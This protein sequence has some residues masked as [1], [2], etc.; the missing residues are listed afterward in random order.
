MLHIKPV[1][2]FLCGIAS[3]ELVA[4]VTIPNPYSGSAP[5]NYV[6]S[7]EAVK[8]VTN[9]NDLTAVVPV[10]TAKMTTQYYDGLGRLIQT[11]NKQGSMETGAAAKDLVS[12]VIYDEFG[13]E[14]YQYL[15]FA[16]NNTG[17]NTSVSDG[18]FKLNPFQQ[19]AVF[20]AAQFPGETF[21]YGK[22]N[23]EASPLNRLVSSYAPGNSW[24]GS[25]GAA[26]E[27]DRHS[28]GK[29]FL[30]NTSAD[31]VRIWRV[32]TTGVITSTDAYLQGTL[33]K[34]VT[35]DEHKKKI[36]EYKDKDG[37]VVLRKVQI[38]A[39]P[40]EG[41]T[42]WMST[43]Y[44]YDDLNLLRLIIPPKATR[45][46]AANSWSLTTGILNELCFR[47]E[48][49]ERQRTIVKKIPGAAEVRMVY[50]KRDRMVLSQDGNQRNAQRWLYTQYDGLNRPVKSGLLTD[51]AHYNDHTW[52]REQAMSNSNPLDYPVLSAYTHEE[53]TATFY[54][55][56]NWLAGYG[57]P[58]SADLDTEHAAQLVTAS[59]STFPYPQA[60]QKSSSTKSLMTGAR[61]KV[62]GTSDWIYSVNI[63]DNK[64]RIIQVK[65][66]NKTGGTDISTTQYAWAG[67]PVMTIQKSQKAGT[68]AQ[69]V[70]VL[71]RL[72][73]DA[74]FR[75]SATQ[76]K[77]ATSV[78]NGGALPSVWTTTVRTEYDALGKVKK[79]WLHPGESSTSLETL[80]YEHSIRGWVTGMNR[81]FVKDEADN[82][83]GFELAY[84]K[85]GAII[86]G[87]GYANAQ[88]NGNIGG[89]IWKSK[90]DSE[91]R[92]YDF[93]YDAANRLLKA[94]F[95]QY[96]SGVFNK[97]AGID[98]SVKM[99]DGIN[100]DSAYDY[101]GNI[102]RLQQ[103][104]LKAL[105]STQIDD[106]TYTYYN[107]GN[108]LKNVI[109]FANDTATR[110]GDFRSSRLYMTALSNNKTT[111]AEDYTYDYN[112]NLVN[113][114]NKDIADDTYNGI[115]YNYLG[116]PV[117]M[118]VKDKGTIEYQYD[119]TG[120]KLAKIIKETGKPD[121]T[122]LYLGNGIYLNDT[123]QQLSHE[124]GRL[125]PVGD[126][127]LAYDYFIK[128]HLGSVRAVLTAEEQPLAAYHATM[129][130][131]R[132]TVE[133]QLFSDIDE[134]ESDKPSGFDSD[135][136]NLKVSK[137]FS[138]SGSDKRLGPSI[139]LKVMAG[140][141]FKAGVKGWYLPGGTNTSG[142]P[143]VENIVVSLLGSF[144]GNMPAGAG[145]QAVISGPGNTTLASSLSGFVTSENGSP[146]SLPKAYL[147]WMVLDEQLFSLVS[148]NYGAVQIPSITGVME[149]QLMLAN[150]GSDIEVKRNGYL[151]IYVSN[152]SQGNV[153]FD[154]LF[155]THT[156]GAL[157]EETHY[158]PSGLT[159]AGISA[160]AFGKVDNKFEF[161]GKE[162]Q[163]KEFSDGVGLEWYDFGARM[164]DPQLSRWFN[165][166]KFAEVYVTLTPYQ[167][168]AN[169]PVKTIDVD[170][171]LLK[172][173]DGNIIATSTGIKTQ[174]SRPIPI[175][176]EEKAAGVT[177]QQVKFEQ[178][179][180][181]VYTDKGTP[182]TAFRTI[183]AYIETEHADGTVTTTAAS[184]AFKKEN[185]D[186]SANCHGYSL[187]GGSIWITDDLEKVLQDEYTVGQS[188]NGA[189][190]AIVQWEYPDGDIE[191][192]HSGV[193]RSDGKYDHDDDVYRVEKGASKE[194]FM[195]G[196][197]GER[198]G[199]KTNEL[200]GKKKTESKKSQTK[201]GVV[202]N[203]VRITD[204]EEINKIFKELGIIK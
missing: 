148:G 103:W 94:D 187:A 15:P 168:A 185:L 153:Y 119:A 158:Y 190:I 134:T 87:T 179:Q 137:L 186:V 167:Y 35:I 62:L 19:Q 57:N 101:N 61:I 46:L 3:H 26:N 115:E 139:L 50:D 85:T 66:K 20:A 64:G 13:R 91:K 29:Q 156:Q 88:Y 191:Y 49:D 165:H 120:N 133:T 65:T 80:T 163:D 17:G 180:I 177:R 159:M 117:K 199:A 59:N 43:Y 99:G 97:S 42:G 193:I 161:S 146:G 108:R 164:Y 118:R 75:D 140:D 33:Y 73:Y 166:D 104:G 150:G 129:E 142:L 135:G 32:D 90:G 93:T 58:L 82:Y 8:P 122:F 189:N 157:L 141:K 176:K 69:T 4:Q 203:G 70:L 53:L 34:T 23:Y 194:R 112:G 110:I 76:K 145:K 72:H 98:F 25:E 5:V 21:F 10:Q 152:E 170:G 181:T 182:V 124:E 22:N 86:N 74:L 41:H 11:V 188:V 175:S 113:D 121:K 126:S 183:A 60:V 202:V 51:A 56:Y 27:A 1:F 37:Q 169:N 132:R 105:N 154:D 147:N 71:T 24:A 81:A 106:L 123:L 102:L 143:G 95:N 195:Q 28:I 39:A 16:A 172:D 18:L 138:S 144:I 12:T 7:W 78:I 184:E 151:F 96:T 192:A 125:R 198:Y 48:Y 9:A 54:D 111:A 14:V 2:F 162:K 136:Q 100:P 130:T 155:V 79:K 109:D 77:V 40:A 55:D 200:Q 52:H 47:Y 174:E 204:E 149:R 45:E 201:A 38:A 31:S 196:H 197:R 67:K 116:Q 114:L 68:N 178:E 92:K 6:R 36:V 84:D 131:A 30:V 171:H 107:N 127:L 89:M 44:V 160:K 83:F 173:K 63:Y 128:D